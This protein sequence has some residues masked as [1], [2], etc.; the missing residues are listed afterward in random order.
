MSV[1]AVSVLAIV[2]FRGV[3]S[4]GASAWCVWCCDQ[5]G[6]TALLLA[7]LHGHL[8]VARWLVTDAGSDA[9]LER[10]D[11][12]CAGLCT[13]CSICLRNQ[14][15]L[16]SHAVSPVR[17]LAICRCSA[18]R[19]PLCSHAM[20]STGMLRAGSLTTKTTIR[21]ASVLVTVVSVVAVL[22]VVCVCVSV[23]VSVC[24][25]VCLCVCVYVCGCVPVS[26]SV[27]VASDRRRRP[28]R[29]A[30]VGA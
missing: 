17:G 15:I 18:G 26:V 11:V 7:C 30:T 22:T 9:R 4:G 24:V 16:L 6:A 8:D 19:Q 21:C 27:S 20:K 10:D 5:K 14:R 29:V 28:R 1:I 13:V 23:C 2:P 25:C 12:S 3:A